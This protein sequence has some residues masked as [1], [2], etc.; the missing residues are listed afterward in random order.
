[1]LSSPAGAILVRL[2]PPHA[3]DRGDYVQ[4]AFDQYSG[5]IL[6]DI[7]SRRLGFAMRAVLF[8]GPLHFGTFAGHWS[9]IAWILTG[10]SPALLFITGFIMWWRRIT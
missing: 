4:L 6:S 3:E 5:K 7:D 10:L 2:A 9:K 1:L 8:M